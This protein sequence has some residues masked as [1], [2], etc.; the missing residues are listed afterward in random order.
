[1]A[2]C[3]C[4]AS[5]LAALIFAGTLFVQQGQSENSIKLAGDLAWVLLPVPFAITAALI[6]SRQP[7]NVIGWLL[8]TPVCLMLISNPLDTYMSKVTAPPINPDLPFLLMIWFSGWDWLALI[9]PLL[10]LTLLFPTGR[11]PSARWRW[12]LFLAA[13]LC[14]VFLFIV[15]FGKTLSD[16]NS[17]WSISNPIGFIDDSAIQSFIGPWQASL[18]VMTILCAGSLFVRY[19]RS[20]SI[21]RQQIKWLLYACG[22][23]AV[24][25]ILGFWSNLTSGDNSIA[26]NLY[27]LLLSVTILT[28]PASIAM[29]ILRYHLW[30]IDILIRRTLI[31]TLL[32]ATLALFYFGSILVLQQI[33][34]FM[35]GNTSSIAIVIST[36]AIAALFAPLRKRVQNFIDRSFYRQKYD[37]ARALEEFNAATRREVQLERL[38]SLLVSVV[39]ETVHPDGIWMWIRNKKQEISTNGFEG[40]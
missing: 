33:F 4:T 12:V 19:R 25:Y 22:V 39:E 10:L 15:T 20:G 21:E 31:Y 17:N 13:G 32:T 3:L 16:S 5:C 14:I 7:N 28:F 26:A 34:R 6:V 9:F 24:I 36:L 8:M 30:D 29:A 11:P 23:F 1:M 35:T 18:I 2:W 37:A 38:T 40:K 27:N